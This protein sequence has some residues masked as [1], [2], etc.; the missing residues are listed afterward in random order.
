MTRL[1]IAAIIAVCTV[2][3]AA[4]GPQMKL[5]FKICPG[6]PTADEAIA[7]LGS[8]V[9]NV[10]PLTASGDCTYTYEADGKLHPESLRVQVRIEPPMNVY[11]Q[12]GSIIGKTVELGANDSEFWITL[13]P[14]KISTYLWGTWTDEGV[15][16]CL[17]KLWFGPKTWLEAFGVFKPATSADASAIWELS[18]QGS[19]DILT[20][21]TR[22]GILTR[23]LHIYCCDYLPRKIEYFDE[24]GRPAAVMD[25]DDYVPVVKGGGW[26][27]PRKLKI[28]NNKNETIDVELK[29]VARGQFTDKQRQLWF[30][31]P[32]AEG[33]EH[34][35]RMNADCQFVE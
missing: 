8:Q 20:R 3:L 31:R 29:N 19:Y 17:D 18:H 26:Q 32:P 1:K 33:F 14:E 5:P 25:L 7:A 35:G 10:V 4:C 22:S 23:R 12:G 15:R 28:T 21:K 27:V 13:R 6:K 30:N 24:Q 16:T 2:C 9:K 11:L 34:V